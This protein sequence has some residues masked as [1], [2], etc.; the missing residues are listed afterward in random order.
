MPREGENGGIGADGKNL[1]VASRGIA[2]R[3]ESAGIGSD[4]ADPFENRGLRP[5]IGEAGAST[6]PADRGV[7]VRE[8]SIQSPLGEISHIN[9][10]L[11][12]QEKW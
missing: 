5:H 12:L 7:S 1:A 11:F 10:S 8:I 6:G 2:V 3:A 4:C 9:S